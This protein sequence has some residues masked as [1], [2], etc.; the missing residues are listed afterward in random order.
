LSTVLVTGANRG[1]GL[2]FAR[3]YAAD[4]WKVYA[5]CRDPDAAPE[6]ARLAAESG[7]SIRVLALEVT[8]A[9]SVRAAAQSLAGEAID[10]LINNAGVGSPKKQRLGSLDYSAWARVLDVNTLGPMRVVEAFLDSV[11]KGGDRK[12]VTLTSAMGSIADNGSGGSYAYRSSKAA[13]NIVVKSLSIDLA[14]RGITCVVV[15]PGWVRT[16]MGGP[17]GKLTPTESVAALRRLI[18]GLKP[19]DTGRFFNYDGKTYPW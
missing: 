6:L 10:V 12:I 5:T 1:L 18:A 4:G 16:D 15:H 17:D 14:P 2:E 9:A 8:D 7:G 11:A 19:E 3:Q 13:V